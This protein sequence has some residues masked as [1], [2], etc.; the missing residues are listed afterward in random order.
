[1]GA[2]GQAHGVYTHQDMSSIVLHL[3]ISIDDFRFLISALNSPPSP[4]DMPARD[5]IM[6]DPKFEIQNLLDLDY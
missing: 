1:V 3:A 6:Q 4:A 5:E 2:F